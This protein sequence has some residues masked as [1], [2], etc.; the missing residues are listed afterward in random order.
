MAWVCHALGRYEQALRL[1]DRAIE[2]A[3]VALGMDHRTTL[4]YRTNRARLLLTVDGH[5]QEAAADCD[6]VLELR[7]RLF[8]DSHQETALRASSNSGVVLNSS[9]MERE[10]DVT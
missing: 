5:S 9:L 1:Y 8:P 2:I 4:I 6:P 10:G 7:R 3:E